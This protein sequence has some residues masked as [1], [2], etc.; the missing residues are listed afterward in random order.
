SRIK[1]ICRVSDT[2]KDGIR[3]IL[4]Y[5]FASPFRPINYILYS[6]VLLFVARGLFK[7]GFIPEI[8]HAHV[9]T[10]GLPALIL[11]RL[12]GIPVV[13]SEHWSKFPLRKLNLFGKILAK[14]VMNR[15][16]MILPVSNS[17]KVTLQSY[18]IKGRF[19][20]VPNVVDTSL[21]YPVPKSQN[22][23]HEKKILFVGSLSPI[24]GLPHLFHALYKLGERRTDWHLDI[25]GEGPARREYERMV[26]ELGLTRKVIFQSLRPKH[27]VAEF[28]RRADLLVL[29]SLVET[30]GVVA[31]EALAAGTPVL[32]TRC[33]GPEEFVTDEVG[34][35]IPPGDADALYKGLNHM[36]DN[37]NRYSYHRISQYA[38]ELFSPERLGM[39]LHTIYRSLKS[40][41]QRQEV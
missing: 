39:L 14:L 30:F 31:A 32:S 29:P 13:L 11:G 12:Y 15:V 22:K 19:K 10:A 23:N 28:M 17:L 33:G 21:F 1:R 24:K 35:L 3:T 4:I 38:C 18:G 7:K 34:L 40:W 16:D 41:N 26:L 27:E 6:C 2:I 25:V 20:I 5:C 36:L 37:L 9:Y 8:I